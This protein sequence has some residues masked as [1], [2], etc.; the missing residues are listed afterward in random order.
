MPADSEVQLP[1]TWRPLGVRLAG[2][3]FGGL[4]LVVCAVAWFTFDAE[5][6]AKFTV[7]QRG[8]LVF[9]GLIAFAA[10]F[11]LVRS[12]VVAEVDRL[13]VVNGYRKRTYEWAEVLAVHLPPGAPW[14]ILDLADGT[15]APAMGIQGSDGGRARVAV[16]QLRALLAR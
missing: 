15:S 9:L 1:H 7:F 16:R 6:R 11:A 8:T 4:L 13:V 2:A 5:T 3:F 10:G 14:A 12:R